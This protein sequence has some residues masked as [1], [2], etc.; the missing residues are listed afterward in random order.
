MLDRTGIQ[1]S[2]KISTN[3]TDCSCDM[4]E[5]NLSFVEHIQRRTSRI[6]SPDVGLMSLCVVTQWRRALRVNGVIWNN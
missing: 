5:T 3:T 2:I 4:Y 1:M 6:E